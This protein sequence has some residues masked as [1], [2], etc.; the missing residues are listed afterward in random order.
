MSTADR[1]VDHHIIHYHKITCSWST[2]Y[3]SYDCI[4]YHRKNWRVGPSSSNLYRCHVNHYHRT[5]CRSHKIFTS[6]NSDPPPIGS[7]NLT[8]HS[9]EKSSRVCTHSNL[10]RV[11][12]CLDNFVRIERQNPTRGGCGYLNRFTTTRVFLSK[13]SSIIQ[14]ITGFYTVLF[15]YWGSCSGNWLIS[16]KLKNMLYELSASASAAR[17]AQNI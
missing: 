10:R 16:S 8:N 11:W 9:R 15:L 3:W 1:F 7:T 12:G 6:V 17:R 13:N 2:D 14:Q 5:L 4:A